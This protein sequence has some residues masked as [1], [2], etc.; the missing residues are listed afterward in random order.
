LL[1]AVV[2]AD[3]ASIKAKDDITSVQK[4]PKVK[5]WTAEG[6]TDEDDKVVLKHNFE[7]IRRV[8]W[9]YVGIVRSKKSLKSAIERINIERREIATL[10]WRNTIS[11]SILET[12]NVALI[13]ELICSSAISRLESRGLHFMEDYPEK[14]DTEYKRDTIMQRES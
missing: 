2:F 4:L 7:E 13:A 14:N 1:E 3:R 11:A 5:D 12:R 9:N 8:M 6:V 10:Y